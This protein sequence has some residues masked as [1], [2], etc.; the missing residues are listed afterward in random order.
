MYSAQ[1]RN[2]AYT[3]NG[4]FNGNARFLQLQIPYAEYGTHGILVG[5]CDRWTVTMTNVRAN[6]WPRPG[7]TNTNRTQTHA[8]ARVQ[9]GSE[10]QLIN[11]MLTAVTLYVGKMSHEPWKHHAVIIDVHERKCKWTFQ[12]G[13]II[14]VFSLVN[15]RFMILFGM[16]KIIFYCRRLG[17][18][19]RI[20]HLFIRA[21]CGRCGFASFEMGRQVHTFVGIVSCRQSPSV[22]STPCVCA[23]V[24]RLCFG[25]RF[26]A[27]EWRTNAF[28][29]LFIAWR[30][31]WHLTARQSNKIAFRI[32]AIQI[33]IFN[34]VA[35]DNYFL[36]YWCR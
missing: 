3:F 23:F 26:R 6:H 20:V 15:T 30:S 31:I 1:C 18:L 35:R 2:S 33:W 17:S 25:L 24:Q 10:N 12:P 28:V 19:T 27:L 7:L 32:W 16:R 14:I 21:E 4:K 13:R 36:Q 29:S 5:T 11:W 22:G 9:Q 34:L 8:R